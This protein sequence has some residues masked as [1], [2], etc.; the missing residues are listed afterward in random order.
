MRIFEASALVALFIT[1]FAFGEATFISKSDIVLALPFDEGEYD[2]AKDLSLYRN[3][4]SLQEYPQWV[5]GKFGKALQFDSRNYVEVENDGS[6]RLYDSGFTLAVWAYFEG[7]L[8]PEGQGLPFMA[9]DEGAGNTNKWIWGRKSAGTGL[10][11]NTKNKFR[12]LI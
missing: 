2:D 8:P 5:D 9:H 6:L 12:D 4:G 10:H 3:D 1:T 7:K 11:T